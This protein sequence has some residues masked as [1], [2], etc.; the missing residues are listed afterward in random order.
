VGTIQWNIMLTRLENKM[1]KHKRTS[2]KKECWMCVNC[3]KHVP[4][5]CYELSLPVKPKEMEQAEACEYFDYD[6]TDME[7]LEEK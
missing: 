5:F 2:K 3:S 7:A 1:T 4:Y 6:E